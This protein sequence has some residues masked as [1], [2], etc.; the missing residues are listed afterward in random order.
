[1][2]RY[3][4]HIQL[5]DFGVVAQQ[6]LL[7]AKVLVVG[8]GGLGVPVLQYLTAM[9]VG[10]IGIVEFDVVSLSNLHRQVL[11]NTGDIG[12]P[13]IDCAV[14]G[15]TPINP[16]VVFQ[17]YPVEL[18]EHNALQIIKNYDMVVD[19]TDQIHTRYVIN[20]A[21][22]MLH[23]PFVYGG[24]HG[25]E[26]QVCVFN[27]KGSATYRCAFPNPP[28]AHEIPTCNEQ[29]VLGILPAIV[30]SYQANE[31]IKII[32]DLG[33]VLAG[34]LLIID[35][36][37]NTFLKIHIPLQPQHLHI[38]LSIPIASLQTI[39]IEEVLAKNIVVIDIR[40]EE[41]YQTIHLPKSDN[42]PFHQWDKNQIAQWN[43]KN[44]IYLICKY[45]I[46]SKQAAN[47]LLQKG[48]QQIFHIQ[49]GIE[50]YKKMNI[51]Q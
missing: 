19:A 24:L 31:V 20:D 51:K 6:K 16:D 33:E 9:G 39:E 5:K 50:S 30:G 14:K 40:N 37:K 46:A 4:R 12:K 36:F 27:Y 17:K 2:E 42:I 41:E 7:Q 21:C 8:A 28:Q 48:F 18:N 45:G 49:G 23:K 3:I 1:M 29:G 43:K 44:P 32:T 35:I 38:K 11:Y 25:Y 26:G 15:L 34:K 22:V 47:I 10:T 13:K